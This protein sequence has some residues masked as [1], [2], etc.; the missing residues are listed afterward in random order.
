M[1]ATTLPPFNSS[2]DLIAGF[3]PEAVYLTHYGQLRDVAPKA[4]ILHRLVDAHAALALRFRDA[5]AERY[6][7]L[8]AGVRELLLEEVR[9]YAGPF[10]AERA[11]EVYAMDVAL[12]A[13]GLVAWLD[14][15]GAGQS[16]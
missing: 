16:S 9:R 10:P 11:L 3:A 6:A 7:A 14:S 2:I 12:N 15:A 5:G 4:A 8:E 1:V 13:Q